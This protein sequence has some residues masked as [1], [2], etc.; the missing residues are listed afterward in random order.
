MEASS[1]AKK[2][3]TI[4]LANNTAQ[5]TSEYLR[6]LRMSPQLPFDGSKKP[7]PGVLKK[8]F[9]LSPMNPWYKRSLL[10]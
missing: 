2:K 10:Y 3:V 7:P 9:V 5:Q 8:S 1:S 6:Q 4:V